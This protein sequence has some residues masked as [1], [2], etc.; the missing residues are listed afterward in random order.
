MKLN[1]ALHCTMYLMLTYFEK[2]NIVNSYYFE[3]LNV[4]VYLAIWKKKHWSIVVNLGSSFIIL[5]AVDS[6]I[7]FGWSQMFTRH[8]HSVISVCIVLMNKTICAYTMTYQTSECSNRQVMHHA[9]PDSCWIG[10]FTLS[11]KGCVYV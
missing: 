5:I 4:K 10:G 7:R 11:G 8:L 1:W 2:K 3:M 6:M 9:C